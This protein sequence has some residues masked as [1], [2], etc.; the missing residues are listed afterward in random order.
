ME[1]TGSIVKNI[2][3]K[4]VLANDKKGARL[5]N[6]YTGKKLNSAVIGG[7]VGLGAFAAVGGPS[8]FKEAP[9]KQD[10]SIESNTILGNQRLLKSSIAPPEQAVN[11]S[12]LAGGRIPTA[13]GSGSKAPDLGATGD[14]VFGMHNGRQGGK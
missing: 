6:F 4:A 10:L 8:A 13:G 11:P 7:A 9:L 2:A 5:A 3:K 14:L 1:T 12:I